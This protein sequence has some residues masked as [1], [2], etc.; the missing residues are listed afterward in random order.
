MIERIILVSSRFLYASEAI[1]EGMT[2]AHCSG[3]GKGAGFTG[4][5]SSTASLAAAPEKGPGTECSFAF[6]CS[7][8]VYR[9][10]NEQTNEI[11]VLRNKRKESEEMV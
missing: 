6:A 1:L 11:L 7:N 9:K 3:E 2:Y 10:R 4:E 8:T 5:G